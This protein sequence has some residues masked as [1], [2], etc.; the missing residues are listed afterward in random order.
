[1]RIF[2]RATLVVLLLL[3]PVAGTAMAV[4][5]AQLVELAKAGLS[6][7]VLIALIETDG[8]TFQLSAADILQLHRAGLEQRRHSGDAE[9]RPEQRQ[10]GSPD[11]A[12]GRLRA[13]SGTGADRPGAGG[14]TRR[15]HACASSTSCRRSPNA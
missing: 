12:P 15:P 4:T 3:G 13:R 6:D 11:R 2:P 7:E 14:A 5:T 1:M 10:G 8:S 9:G